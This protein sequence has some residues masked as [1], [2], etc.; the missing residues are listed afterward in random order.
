MNADYSVFLL[1]DV[2]DEDGSRQIFHDSK[3]YD[4]ALQEMVPAEFRDIAVLFDQELLESWY[5]RIPEHSAFF[6]V[7]QPMQLFSQLFKGFDHYWQLEMDMKIH[8]ERRAMAAC[9]GQVCAQGTTKAISGAGI[10][11]LHARGTWHV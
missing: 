1:V 7:Y 3:S 2:K 6:Q 11:L 9:N 4:K 5:P 8:W 10:V